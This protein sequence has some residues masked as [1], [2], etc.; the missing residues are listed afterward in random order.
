MQLNI[1]RNRQ[2]KA[3]PNELGLLKNLFSFKIEG[4]DLLRLPKNL[5]PVDGKNP[6][7]LLDFLSQRLVEQVPHLFMKIFV[8]GATRSEGLHF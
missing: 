8:V 1:S 7:P 3:L 5:R 4:L 2:L 6:R